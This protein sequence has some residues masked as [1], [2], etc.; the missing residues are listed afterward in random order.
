VRNHQRP[1]RRWQRGIAIILA[2]LVTSLATILSV[3][4]SSNQALFFRRTENIIRQ[5]QAYQYLLGAEDFGKTVLAFDAQQN[6]TDSMQDAWAA[7]DPKA[8]KGAPAGYTVP[9]EA[10]NVGGSIED[11]QG[12]FNINNLADPKDKASL[13][14]FR[15]LLTI[16]N[17]PPDLE[18]AV[19]DWLDPDQN[20]RFPDGAEDV[21][22]LQGERAYRAANALMG[23]VSELLFVKGFNYQM[24][25]ALAPA[26]IALPTSGI[27]VNVNTATPLVLRMI[28]KGLSQQDAET[29]AN[30]LAK[31]PVTDI[32][33]F[34]SNS[35]VTGKPVDTTGID[36]RSSY[37]MIH[38][39]ANVGSARA[40]L[41]SLIYRAAANNIKTLQRSQGGV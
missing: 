33:D 4:L 41:D 7:T 12:R 10:G 24:Y 39:Y 19:L 20:A 26:L 9:V 40:H 13:D 31:K 11:A 37:F 27:H 2:L 8:P 22:Y 1:R 15:E 38:A 14:A 5:E 21:D 28:V 36:V 6:N 17:I 29:L 32:K 16:N 35:L 34:L 18:N 23:S 3:S 25:E 30:D